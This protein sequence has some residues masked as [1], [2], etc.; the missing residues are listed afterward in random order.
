M[1][2]NLFLG[3]S[4]ALEQLTAIWGAKEVLF[5]VYEHGGVTFKDELFVKP[6][7]ISQK[8]KLSG[9][10]QKDHKKIFIPMEYMQIGDYM[11]VQTDYTY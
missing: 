9:I 10:I 8:G 7:S 1:M 3:P 5:K 2:K 4:P 11:L 6:F